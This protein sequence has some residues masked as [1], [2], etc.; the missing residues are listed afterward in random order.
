MW[1]IGPVLKNWKVLKYYD[2]DC[3]KF[4]FSCSVH[5]QWWLKILQK[6]LILL[7][8]VSSIKKLPISKVKSFLKSNFLPKSNM[9]HSVYTISLN[10]E[11]WRNWLVLF[12]YCR[13]EKCLEFIENV[14]KSE[15]KWKW[16]DLGPKMHLLR[17]FRT[18]Y[19]ERDWRV[20]CNWTAKETFGIFF[21]VF[22]TALS[23]FQASWRGTGRLAM[24]PTKFDIF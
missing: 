4:I 12:F 10:L 24:H 7:K 6:V 16:V 8:K 22:L 5:F 9:Q 2:Q 17:Q 1:W 13:S 3:L 19:L 21:C 23:R 11:P 20:Q 18:G 15:L 14:K